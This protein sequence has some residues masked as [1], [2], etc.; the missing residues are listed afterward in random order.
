MARKILFRF[1]YA[2]LLATAALLLVRGTPG[3]PDVPWPAI[4]VWVGLMTLTEAAPIRLPGGGVITVSSILDYAGLIVFGPYL[5]AW[6]A[7]FSALTCRVACTP[8]RPFY[9]TVFNMALYVVTCVAAGEA[10]LAS[11]GI[12]G[13][14]ELPGNFPAIAAM[15]LVYFVVN[16]LG[17]SLVISLTG[18]ESPAQVWGVNFRWTIF[19]LLAFLPFGCVIAL[20]YLQLGY[21]GVLLFMFPLLLARYTFKVYT[22]MRQDFLDFVGALT[23]IIEEVDPYTRLHSHRV[24]RHA[25]QIAT[26]MGLSR[27]QVETIATSALLHDIGKVSF[28]TQDIIDSPGLLTPEQRERMAKHPIIGAQIVSRIRTL[29][30]AAESVRTHHE[31]MDGTGYPLGLAGDAIPIGARIVMA[32]DALDAMTSDRSYRRALPLEAAIAELRRQAGKQFDPDVVNAVERLYHRQEL[33][34]L[35][36]LGEP[37]VEVGTP[38]GAGRG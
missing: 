34:V 15:G 32:A 28:R 18:K 29:K 1:Y 13:H 10:F 9:K 5:T 35:H 20:V 8:R 4:V 23:S 22:E 6:V 33:G 26:E 27:S 31:R 3:I 19:H 37:P 36:E 16:T 21:L 38:V 14:M 2:G 17:V 30:D 12:V 7:L 11:G 24:S 25:R